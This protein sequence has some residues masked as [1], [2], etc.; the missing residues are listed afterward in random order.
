MTLGVHSEAGKLRTVMVCRPGLAH[1]R[2]T[3]ANCDS[4]LFDDVIWVDRAIEDHETFVRLMRERGVEVLEF[5]H[6]LAQTLLDRSA[7]DWLLDRRIVEEEVGTGMLRELRVWLEELPAQQLADMLI[8]GIAKAEVPFDAK[9]LFGGYLERSEF[10][11]PP[12]ANLIFQRDPSAW[13]YGGVT[14][15]PMYWPAR[16]KETLLL[17]AV[18]RFHPRFAGQVRVWWGD[19]DIDH[20]AQTLE[21][22][23]VMAIGNGVVLIGMGERSSPQAVTQVARRLFAANAARRVIACQLPKARASM[24]LDTVFSFID[25]DFVSI[26]PDVADGILCTS[27]YPGDEQGRI[28]YERHTQAFLDV[29]AQALGVGSL[30]VLTT[31]GD[32]YEI[33]R[34]QWDDGNNVLA[35]DRRVVLA[36]DRNVYTN[37]KMRQAGVEVIEVPGGEL[38]RGRGGSHCLTCPVARDP[39]EL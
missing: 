12:L 20:G 18:Y 3:P 22:G 17:T 19:P 6:L 23:D 32:A 9:G 2:L 36:Y 28:R 10:V 4:L 38:G 39:I 11:I 37:R 5:H 26:Y 16:R 29:I 13:V 21:G 30:R 14:L 33:E 7:R 34:E 8:G 35:L 27:L 1:R 25:V 15:N 31:G 24:H